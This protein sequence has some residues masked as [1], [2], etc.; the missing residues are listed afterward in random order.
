M[1]SS[2]N[3]FCVIT[4]VL[5]KQPLNYTKF[6]TYGK[7]YE[8]LLKKRYFFLIF[9]NHTETIFTRIERYLLQRQALTG[10]IAYR[11]AH[12]TV[13]DAVVTQNIDHG[14]EQAISYKQQEPLSST[15]D[16]A[17][18]PKS[19]PLPDDTS[20]PSLFGEGVSTPTTT[21][22]KD[23]ASAAVW[24]SS[25]TLANLYEQIHTCQNCKLGATR[26]NFVFGVGNPNAGLMVIGEAPGADEDAQ[27]EPFVGRGGQ[28]LTKILEAIDFK[29]EDVYIANIIKCRPPENRRPEADEVVECEPYLYKQID[30]VKPTFILALGLTAV[31]TLLKSKHTMGAIR[32]KVLEFRGIPMMTT[33][34]P[35]ALL[36][37]PEWKRAAWEDVQLLRKLYDETLQSK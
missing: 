19:V 30:L 28:L 31:N 27:G 29:R 1:K 35:A 22:K 24:Q 12:N 3:N 21:A 9:M 14:D 23:A 26:T 33:Y 11:V 36:R 17:T 37:N 8:V 25:P 4:C 18:M 6:S 10:N 20:L 2:K 32:G 34:H 5:A 15:K 16:V 13:P 7:I